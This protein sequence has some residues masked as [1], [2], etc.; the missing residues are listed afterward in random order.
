MK[1]RVATIAKHFT[2]DAAH[3]L[4]RLPPDHMCNRMHGHT[5]QVELVLVGPVDDNGFVVD[6][7][8]IA[9]AFK[10]AIHSKVDHR[11]LNDVPGL[12]VPTTEN[13]AWWI[14]RELARHPLLRGPAVSPRKW[15]RD[16]DNAKE[17]LETTFLQRVRVKESSTTWCEV[18]VD[19]DHAR[20]L[21]WCLSL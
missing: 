8:D 6:Y 5:Y 16:E 11:T 3:R 17:S 2:F 10:E 14:I 13:L 18:D 20:I 12:E 21:P 15:M 9:T 7:A 4:D 19:A 1:Q